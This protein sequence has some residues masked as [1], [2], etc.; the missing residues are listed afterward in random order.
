MQKINNPSHHLSQELKHSPFILYHLPYEVTFDDIFNALRS[1]L[2]EDTKLEAGH[3]IQ[4]PMLLSES[5]LVFIKT[6]EVARQLE[7][8]KKLTINGSSVFVLPYFGENTERQIDQE[9]SKRIVYVAGI[10][11]MAQRSLLLS[12][13]RTVAKIR[14][15]FVP[16][17]NGWNNRHFGFAIC[18]TMEDKQ[19]LLATKKLRTEH[20]RLLFSSFNYEKY[21]QNFSKKKRKL[22]SGKGDYDH[23]PNHMAPKNVLVKQFFKGKC[24]YLAYQNTKRAKDQPIEKPKSLQKALNLSSDPWFTKKERK[25]SM[26]K[27]R[28]NSMPHNF[29]RFD[30]KKDREGR[31]LSL[32]IEDVKK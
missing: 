9:L 14:E 11:T 16:R 25:D 31:K 27:Y 18:E 26:S 12:S 22:L 3:P 17:N 7:A 6:R 15:F 21:F 30:K 4:Q 13:L 1:L 5:R 19:K 20:F 2:S 24:S 29:N 23:L 28:L 10:P 32:Q 8:Q